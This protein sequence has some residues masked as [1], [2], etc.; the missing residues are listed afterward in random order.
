[1]DWFLNPT[2]VTDKLIVMVIAIVLFVAIMSLILWL[3]DRPK[4]PTG[5]WSLDF[6]AR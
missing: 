5:W 1:M 2:S 6:S 4:V 3:I